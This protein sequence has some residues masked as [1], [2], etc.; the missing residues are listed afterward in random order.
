MLPVLEFR[1]VT[2]TYES[3]SGESRTDSLSILSNVSLK[4]LPGEVIAIVGPS[5]SGKSTLLNIAGLLDKPDAGEVIFAD[6]NPNNCVT[7][8]A[9]S[10]QALLAQLRRSS[11]GFVF[12]H[13]HLMSSLTVLQNAALPALLNHKPQPFERARV[14]LERVGLAHRLNYYP[15][16]LSGGEMQR[17]AIARALVHAPR[18]IIADEP[19]GSL[20]SRSGLTVLELLR[21]VSASVPGSALLIATHSA[22]VAKSA[23]RIIEL[24]FLLNTAA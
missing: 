24:P 7:I 16:Q 15:A 5:G 17:C 18:V 23:S 4:I 6:S 10:A 1:N 2:R 8:N 22:Q 12:Q 19:T 13:F 20:D 9:A 11:V 21:E 14:L 3:G